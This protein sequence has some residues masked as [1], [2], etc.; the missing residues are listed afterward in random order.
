MTIN[1]K[2]T[3]KK[4][5]QAPMIETEGMEAEGLMANS[6]NS[7]TEGFDLNE[8]TETNATSGNLSRQ[9]IWDDDEE[10]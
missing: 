10:F 3:M 7:L 4:I 5:Y 8:V 9:T 1:V 2:E 6:V